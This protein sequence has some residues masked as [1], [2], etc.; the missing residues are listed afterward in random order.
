MKK[1]LLL[2]LVLVFGISG[3]VLGALEDNTTVTVTVQYISVGIAGTP[4]F[5][6][7]GAASTF[8]LADTSCTV[9]NDGNWTSKWSF[10]CSNSVP[11]TWT[12]TTGADPASTTEFR[13]C[14]VFKSTAVET[15]DF[16]AANDH[17]DTTYQLSGTATN[18]SFYQYAAYGGGQNVNAT[19]TRNL[20]LSFSAPTGTPSSSA[21]TITVY[22][23][24]QAQ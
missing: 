7:V 10:R 20:W 19:D 4:A 18:E 12:P 5:G 2:S 17:I 15:G 8:N 22:V 9:T 13:L 21:Q 3:V 1:L 11:T 23:Q 16:T 6:T 24:T 14:S